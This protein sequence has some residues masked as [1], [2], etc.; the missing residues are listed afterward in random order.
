M[1]DVY[2]WGGGVYPLYAYQFIAFVEIF[3]SNLWEE[4][5]VMRSLSHQVVVQWIL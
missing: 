1:P 2:V 5:V 3:T 4:C